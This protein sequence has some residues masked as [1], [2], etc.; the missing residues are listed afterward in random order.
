MHSNGSEEKYQSRER[1]TEKYPSREISKQRNIQA[2]KY[3]SRE[4]SKQS[5]V[6]GKKYQVLKTVWTIPRDFIELIL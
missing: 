3:Q 6:E 1:K 4:I 5:H 2:E